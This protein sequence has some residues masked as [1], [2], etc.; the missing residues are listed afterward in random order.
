MESH[1]RDRDPLKLSRDGLSVEVIG[2]DQFYKP[3]GRVRRLANAEEPEI[4]F[5]DY[6]G[7][8]SVGGQGRG[9]EQDN[10]G[11]RTKGVDTFS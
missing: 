6:D 4:I 2:Q 7:I 1:G 8:E 11:I 9:R 10:N 5:Y 3:K